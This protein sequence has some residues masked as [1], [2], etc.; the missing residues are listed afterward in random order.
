MPTLCIGGDPVPEPDTWKRIFRSLPCA[1]S[2]RGGSRCSGGWNGRT[3]SA[4]GPGTSGAVILFRTRHPG[5]G[6][7]QAY[8][9]RCVCFR[10]QFDYPVGHCDPCLVKDV[11][12]INHSESSLSWIA[13]KSPI[14]QRTTNDH[15]AVPG[16][17][18]ATTPTA[19]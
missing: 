3:C 16:S 15:T 12:E 1:P 9:R 4:R 10:G 6:L 13:P 17:K 8:E 5:E 18:I 2:T 7:G 11:T 14:R 19:E